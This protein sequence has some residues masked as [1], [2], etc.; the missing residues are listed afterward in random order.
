MYRIQI[1]LIS[2]LL[3]FVNEGQAQMTQ[4]QLLVD[5]NASDIERLW[6]NWQD[7]YIEPVSVNGHNTVRVV[8]D[9]STLA[10]FSEGQA[11][12]MLFSVL[13][14]DQVLFDQLWLYAQQYMNEKNLMSWHIGQDGVPLDVGAASDADFDMAMALI[15]ACR[16]VQEGDWQATDNYCTVASNMIDA[17]WTHE[18]DKVGDEP[19]GGLTDNQGYEIIPGDSWCLSCDFPA[20]IT[21]PSYFSPAYFTIF[22]DFTNNR[23]WQNVIDRNYDLLERSQLADCSRLVPNWITYDGQAQI[24]DWQGE[25]STYW[26]WDAARVSW[27]L[28]LSRYWFDDSRALSILNEIGGFFDGVGLSNIRAEYRLDGTAVNSY[29]DTFFIAHGANAIWGMTEAIPSSC[30]Q[31]ANPRNTSSQQAYNA[32]QRRLSDGYYNDSWQ[33]LSMLLMTGYF[34]HPAEPFKLPQRIVTTAPTATPMPTAVPEV[35]ISATDS[36]TSTPVPIDTVSE[37]DGV[38]VERLVSVN[39]N[40]QTQFQF[41]VTNDSQEALDNIAVR[42]YFQIDSNRVASE[43]V[44]EI[45]WDSTEASTVNAPIQYRESI[46][47][48]DIISPLPLSSN[49]NWE[50]HGALHLNDWSSSLDGS[51]DWWLQGELDTEFVE[52]PYLPL[53]AN[54]TLV[55][56]ATP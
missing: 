43:Y 28:A 17:I 29:T 50:V 25:S 5:Y 35:Q 8:S 13:M 41:R 15:Y 40:Q 21:N 54:N 2:I 20:G 12:G 38:Y 11:Y 32:V 23:E 56:G 1:L 53:F 52:T 47:Y 24:V 37:I 34:N 6:T 26:G 31:I 14:N 45:Y 44:F 7:N 55:F 51:N 16:R 33:L 22:G 42:L 48:I 18:I 19:A 3:A 4:S 10:T 36:P 30:S 49:S 39:N 9:A 27:R 46:Y